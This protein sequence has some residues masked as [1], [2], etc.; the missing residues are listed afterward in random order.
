MFNEKPTRN[1]II[2]EDLASPTAANE[3]IAIMCAIDTHK[4]R[5]VATADVPNTFIQSDMPE[6]KPG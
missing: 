4:G 5:D 2:K 1:Y 3:S 6:S